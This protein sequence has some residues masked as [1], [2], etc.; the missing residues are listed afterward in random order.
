MGTLVTNISNVSLSVSGNTQQSTSISWN[1]PSIS[2]NA[3]INSCVLTGKA[4]ASMSKG[5]ATITVNG[6]TVSSGSSFSINLGTGNNVN[7]VT[8][9]TKGGNKN[10][11]GTVTFSNL[12][13]TVDYTLKHTVTFLD[14]DGSVLKTEMVEDRKSATAPVDPTRDGYT[15]V[16]WDVDFSNVLSDL[17]VTAKYSIVYIVRFIDY[18]GSILKIQEVFSGESATPP[19]V[20]RYGY[21]LIGWSIDYT[22]VVSNMDTTAQY[23]PISIL[24]LK[25]N[26]NWLNICKI[27]KKVS[28]SWVEQHNDNWTDIFSDSVKFI[29]KQRKLSPTAILYSDGCLIFSDYSDI[30]SSHGSVV[31]VYEDWNDGEYNIFNTPPWS[32]NESVLSVRYEAKLTEMPTN[33][34]RF[35]YLPNVTEFYFENIDVRYTK[36][37]SYMFGGCYKI[38]HLDLSSFHSESVQATNSMFKDDTNLKTVDISNFDMTDLEIDD[39]DNMFRGCT[40]LQT[41]YVKDE[42]A[43]SK[44]ESS[45]NFPTTA[46]VI[47]KNPM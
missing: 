25:E 16:G 27:F 44:I 20:N 38:E 12:E 36:I 33:A 14:Y 31:S 23:E 18:D 24:L 11:S 39:M 37:F 13:Y 19:S 3:T 17:I 29:E 21:R 22:N 28:G 7:S 41:V 40:S 45:T 4:T 35:F 1:L 34:L 10:A 30:D 43:K 8:A 26:G 42:V 5:S 15:F 47:I 46:T 2:G 6:Q 32:D 9:T